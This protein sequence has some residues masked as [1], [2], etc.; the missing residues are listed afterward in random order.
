MT[1]AI[2]KSA[3]QTLAKGGNFEVFDSPRAGGKYWI[4]GTA[5]AL[6]GAFDNEGKILLTTWLCEQRRSGIDIPKIDSNISDIVKSRRRLSIPKRLTA[7]LM[8]IGR[9]SSQL[10]Q[11]ILFGND[12][13]FTQMFCAETESRNPNEI[14]RLLI[15]LKDLSYLEGSFFY[16][17]W[18]VSSTYCRRVA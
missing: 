17:R 5:L 14:S 4:S 11:P 13:A 15:M 1:C 6:V 12:D 9:N 7:A 2:W 10:G 16:F 8:F 3:A 18:C